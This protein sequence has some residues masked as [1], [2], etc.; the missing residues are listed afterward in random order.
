MDFNRT[1]QAQNIHQM[2]FAANQKKQQ[3]YAKLLGKKYPN[4]SANALSLNTS[5]NNLTDLQKIQ[6]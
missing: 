5:D 3:K 4:T 2:K 1:I 6:A